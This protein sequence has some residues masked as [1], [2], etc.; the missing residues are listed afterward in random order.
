MSEKWNI[1]FI[2]P[3]RLM[4]LGG[5]GAVWAYFLPPFLAALL[6]SSDRWCS[7]SGGPV[8]SLFSLLVL[9]VFFFSGFGIFSTHTHVY[10]C[11]LLY[12]H[13]WLFRREFILV[14]YGFVF[15]SITKI[16]TISCYSYY[17]LYILKWVDHFREVKLIWKYRVKN[18]F[19][20]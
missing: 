14:P 3:D 6:F 17:L 12:V 15:F 7:F 19:N 16:L 2:G 1:F 10:I 20:P 9:F 4:C 5:L 11:D 8:Y 13:T 18:H